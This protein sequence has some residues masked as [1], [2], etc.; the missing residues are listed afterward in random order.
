MINSR[1]KYNKRNIARRLCQNTPDG[2]ALPR[3][4]FNL[5]VQ[6]GGGSVALRAGFSAGLSWENNTFMLVP[7]V[8]SVMHSSEEK[9]VNGKSSIPE[10]IGQTRKAF[11]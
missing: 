9:S 6:V 10:L 3:V 1:A 4:G 2:K 5:A 11:V 7:F 8:D